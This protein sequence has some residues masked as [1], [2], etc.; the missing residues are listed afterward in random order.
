MKIFSER[1]NYVLKALVKLVKESSK[2]NPQSV[3]KLRDLSNT[4]PKL[5]K[6]YLVQLLNLLKS[7][8][9][10]ESERGKMGGYK[11]AKDPQNIKVIDIIEA[12]EGPLSLVDMSNQDNFYKNYWSE[13]NLQFKKI[14]EITLK[15]FIDHQNPSEYNI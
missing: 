9:I 6:N 8:G 7:Q 12:I 5:P 15:E 3:V 4:P 1:V 13:K 10:V 2:D 11:L 14:F